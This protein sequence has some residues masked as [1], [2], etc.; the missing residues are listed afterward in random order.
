M[1]LY[2]LPFSHYSSKVRLVLLEKGL[3]VS[4]A[5]IPGGSQNSE[6][7]LVIN[8]TGLVPCLVDGE[9]VLGESEVIAEYLE[10]QYPE[11]P[12]LPPDP[13]ARAKSRWLSRM[14]DLQLGPQL[15]ALYVLSLD[16]EAPADVVEQEMMALYV[17]LDLIEQS[18]QPDPFFFGEQFG[19]SDAS[20]VLSTWYAMVL[21]EV[22]GRP[23]SPDRFPK[24]LTWFEQASRRQSA[25]DVLF[26]CKT[27]LGMADEGV[28]VAS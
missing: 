12:M 18:I 7:Y 5:D 1:D 15:T 3:S 6:E 28:A 26:D 25:I 22:F 19:I 14:H 23:L 24:L 20:Y 16:N 10:E 17:V 21:S 2:Q 13:K 4:L 9:L 8:P 11:K 27:A